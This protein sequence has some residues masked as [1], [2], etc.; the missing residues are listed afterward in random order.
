M[1]AKT[2]FTLD[3]RE[4]IETF[5]NTKNIAV[6]GYSDDPSRPSHYV[7]QY[8]KSRGYRVVGVNPKLAEQSP[9]AGIT[10][11]ASLD[12][13]SG[14]IDM[15]DVFRRSSE[16]AAITDETIRLN[17]KVLWLQQGVIDERSAQRASD[18]GL[19]VMMDACTLQEHQRLIG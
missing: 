11:V 1:T 16:V 19:R 7:A 5:Q 3:D 9:V 2:P 12:R 8:L 10:V 14:P 15:V 17:A 4:L 18:A 13:V 6:V